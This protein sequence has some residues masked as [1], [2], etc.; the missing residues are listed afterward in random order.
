MTDS[1]L[2]CELETQFNDLNFLPDGQTSKLIL[3]WNLKVM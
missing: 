1:K 3:E 2:S